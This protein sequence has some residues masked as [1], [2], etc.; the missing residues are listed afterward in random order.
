MDSF[1]LGPST[2]HPFFEQQNQIRERAWQHTCGLSTCPKANGWF[3]TY[4]GAINGPP[5]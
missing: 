1:S 5:W 4:L 3:Y 2:L